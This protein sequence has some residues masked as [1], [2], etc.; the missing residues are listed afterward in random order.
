[1]GLL[2]QFADNRR[3]N[4]AMMFGLL[5]IPLVM[6]GGLAIDMLR[7]ESAK[8]GI[9]E[10]AD[11]ALLAAARH[12]SK[13]ATATKE[14]LNVL[15]RKVFDA[16]FANAGDI[17]VTEF[18]IDFD[19]D[20]GEFTL[21]LEA[22]M[23]TLLLGIMGISMLDV[24]A[25]SVVVMGPPRP[26]EIALALDNTGS[27]NDNGKIGDL[28][29]AAD[30]LVEELMP[31]GELVDVK[32]SL[33]PFAQYVNVG[34]SF[35]SAYWLDDSDAGFSGCVG[36]RA[37]PDNTTDTDYSTTPIPGVAGNAC[38]DEI[39]PLSSNKSDIKSA[40]DSMDG[41][42]WTYIGAGVAWG[43]RTL[44]AHAPYTGGATNEEI[45][46]KSGIKAL[47]IMTDGKNTRAPDYPTHESSD[48]ILAD[49]LTKE[50]CTA[51]KNDEITVYSIAFDVDDP[52]VRQVLEDCATDPS[53]YFTPDTAGELEE[54]FASIATT[55]RNLS[56]AQ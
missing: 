11:A 55:I 37:Y 16:H 13:N 23:E 56:I 7:K 4:V 14:Q 25:N 45:Q 35:G 10:A 40:I 39:L 5:V 21:D 2:K 54:A 19:L 32:I 33:V 22:G 27:M 51:V 1:M 46:E 34:T 15:G 17:G 30:S 36:S 52:Y 41:D 18:D 3:G 20:E 12:K 43:W 48:D 49:D 38:P 42:G 26:V 24:N 44:S 31:D 8:T 28:K 29:D 53:Y 50:I 47:V 6:A 9:Q